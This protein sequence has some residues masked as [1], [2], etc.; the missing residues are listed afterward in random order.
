MTASIAAMLAGWEASRAT[1][2]AIKEAEHPDLTD[3]FGRTWQW[4]DKDLYTHD[5]LLAATPDVIANVNLGLPRAGLADDNP[6]YAGLCSICRREG[7]SK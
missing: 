5:A 6:N 1:L 3:Q 2:R 7:V 4:K